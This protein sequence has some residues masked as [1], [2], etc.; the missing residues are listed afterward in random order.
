MRDAIHRDAAQP[1]RL[2]H[3]V[4]QVGRERQGRGGREQEHG[5]RQHGDSPAP[6]AR[7]GL[8]HRHEHARAEVGR[9]G[10]AV[11]EGAEVAFERH[12]STPS[13]AAQA[14]ERTRRARLDGA[15]G[16][17]EHG[18]SLLLAEIEHEAAGEHAAI[19]LR[20]RCERL[21]QAVV[22]GADR[23]LRGRLPGQLA[24]RALGQAL[25][26]PAVAHAV[27]R[28]VG[29]DRE[30]PG[31]KLGALPEALERQPGADERLL[32]CFLGVGRRAGD[33]ICGAESDRLMLL[34]EGFVR[35]RVATPRAHGAVIRRLLP[36]VHSSVL[37]P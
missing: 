18:R 21:A 9:V 13:G 10:Q 33:E 17:S 34:N 22:P 24:R 26:A 29:D 36:A 15:A 19:A 23:L 2:E 35:A 32:R 37:H 27:A 3:A 6:P 30:Q 11:A 14:L 1:E 31:A 5:E 28:L 25:A 4:A 16:D 12:A 7:R 20:Q 8:A